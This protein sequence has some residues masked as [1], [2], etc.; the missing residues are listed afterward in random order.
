MAAAPDLMSLP[1][2]QLTVDGA[3]PLD[4]LRRIR[5]P[6]FYQNSAET[7]PVD[8]Y[9]NDGLPRQQR[10]A[11]WSEAPARDVNFSQ[12]Y[13]LA[14]ELTP[15]QHRFE[16]T[17]NQGAMHLGSIYL[18]PATPLPSYQRLSGRPDRAPDTAG[19]C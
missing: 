1:E 11:R 8:R 17:L 2:G 16:F 5:F 12:P 18:R 10:L 3:F 15:G 14:I 13:P 4:D 6:V 9:G 7:F 19:T